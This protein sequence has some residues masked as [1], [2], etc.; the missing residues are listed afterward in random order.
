MRS[1][2]IQAVH[3]NGNLHVKIV[4][5]FDTTTALGAVRAINNGYQKRGNVFANNKQMED[6]LDTGARTLR[7]NM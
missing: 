6:V 5:N 2:Q 1:G 4:G 7:L 3:R